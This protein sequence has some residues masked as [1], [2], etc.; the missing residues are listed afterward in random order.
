[1]SIIGIFRC[2]DGIVAFVDVKN[3]IKKVLQND[4]IILVT[5]EDFI[6]QNKTCEELNVSDVIN[7]CKS[8][9]LCYCKCDDTIYSTGGRIVKTNGC[10]FGDDV[11][12]Y[13]LRTLVRYK[14]NYKRNSDE[15][16]LLSVTEMRKKLNDFLGY[17]IKELDSSFEDNSRKTPLIIDEYY[18]EKC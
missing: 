11:Y 10:Y 17:F 16:K 6:V 12:E 5:Q 18:F 4:H 15:N 9:Y 8:N 2:S 3:K 13:L 7:N 1:M 14:L